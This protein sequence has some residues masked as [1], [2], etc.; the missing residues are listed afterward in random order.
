[1]SEPR[2]SLLYHP[3]VHVPAPLE[4]AKVPQVRAVTP[5]HTLSN[6]VECTP[7]EGSALLGICCFA[8]RLPKS[9]THWKKQSAWQN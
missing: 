7:S 6:R 1:M 2:H 8:M 5:W 4:S 3:S 9:S